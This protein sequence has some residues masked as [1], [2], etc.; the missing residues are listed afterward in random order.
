M[1]ALILSDAWT[2]HNWFMGQ[3]TVGHHF[4]LELGVPQL[5]MSCRV[6]LSV[7]RWSGPMW[8]GQ[9]IPCFLVFLEKS[10]LLYP[11]GIGDPSRC[12]AKRPTNLTLRNQVIRHN[13]PIL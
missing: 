6:I 1:E 13:L 3:Y 5:N 8:L 9:N 7:M 2:I 4:R 12:R 10:A 11:D